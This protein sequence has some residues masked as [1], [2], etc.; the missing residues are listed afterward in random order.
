MRYLSG[1]VVIASLVIL[2]C[3]RDSGRPAGG[4]DPVGG[5][6]GPADPA[7]EKSGPLGAAV[8]RIGDVEIT[9][10]GADVSQGM[11]KDGPDKPRPPAKLGKIQ[12]DLSN[13]TMGHPCLWVNVLVQNNSDAKTIRLK[14]WQVTKDAVATDD[15]GNVY[16]ISPAPGGRLWAGQEEEHVIGPGEKYNETLAFDKPSAKATS[17]VVKLP[18]TNVGGSGEFRIQVPSIKS[19]KA[20]ADKAPATQPTADKSPVTQ[21]DTTDSTLAL[22]PETRQ[23]IQP[24]DSQNR[25]GVLFDN[26]T[27]RFGISCLRLKSTD[28]LKL[29]TGQERGNTNNTVLRLGNYEYVFGYEAAGGGIRWAREKGKTLK[30]VSPPSGRQ[31]YSAMEYGPDHIRIA[32]SVEIIIGEQ[33]R[34]YDTVLVRYEV[35]NKDEKQQAIGLRTMIDTQIGAI[36][37]APFFMPPTEDNQQ[38]GLVDSKIEVAKRAIPQFLRVLESNNLYD[39]SAVVAE[40]GLK[41]RGCQAPDKLVICQWP[42]EWGGSM[43]RWGWPYQAMNQPA[44]K[45]KQPAGTKDSCVVIYWDKINLNAGEKRIVG[46][47]YGLGH[48][49]GERGEITEGVNNQGKIRLFPGPAVAGRPSVATAYLRNADGQTC[50]IKLP[51]GVSLDKDEMGEK[52]VKTEA[53]KEY[54]V[55]TWRVVAS[56]PEEY[57]L[58]AVLSDGAN[59]KVRVNV[60]KESVFD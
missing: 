32:Q 16:K 47:S 3:G 4:V 18:A 36:D 55:V 8:N 52:P 44:G 19:P 17:F 22:M 29:L 40:M 13:M 20:N 1:F 6:S 10:V 41:L 48:I 50:T 35:W 46:Y 53:G 51:V 33:T 21:P 12:V 26:E 9:L 42:Q 30:E 5:K 25:I 60:P 24:L 15:L 27:Q 49:A 45:K 37:G 58:E 38:P 14:S 7:A 43:V 31:W 56:K 34:L 59:S 2:G 23:A 54:A 28:K 39:P 11:Y 57:V